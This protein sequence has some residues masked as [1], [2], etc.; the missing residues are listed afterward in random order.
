MKGQPILSGQKAAN[1]L[2]I[3]YSWQSTE[4]YF[5]T[6]TVTRSDDYEK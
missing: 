6:M 1:N 3:E 5:L 2:I 4:Y